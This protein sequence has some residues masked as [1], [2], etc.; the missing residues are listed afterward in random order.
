MVLSFYFHPAPPESKCKMLLYSTVESAAGTPELKW[1]EPQP[2]SE[3]A[4][5]LCGTYLTFTTKLC[6]TQLNL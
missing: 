6:G 4:T 3:E 1:E 5:R 2:N